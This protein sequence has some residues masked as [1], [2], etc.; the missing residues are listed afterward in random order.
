MNSYAAAHKTNNRKTLMVLLVILGLMIGLVAA[1]VPLYRLFCQVTG[2]G[3]T[4]QK[5]EAGST[6]ILGREMTIRFNSDVNSQL[7]WH[8]KPVQRSVTVKIGEEALIF[9]RAVNNSNETIT[10]TATFN[11]TPFKAAP[12]FNKIE[13]FCFTEQTLAPGEEVDMPVSFYIDP[14]LATDK[15]LDEVKEI[16]LSYTFFRAEED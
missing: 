9:Y 12:Y 7:P 15:R 6:T 8:F 16:T 4:T 14:D 10:G 1:S 11:V 13:C 5:V 2:Y 3:G